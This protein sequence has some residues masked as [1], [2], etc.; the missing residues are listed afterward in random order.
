M[1]RTISGPFQLLLLTI[2]Y[3]ARLCWVSETH[4]LKKDVEKTS[5]FFE[6]QETMEGTGFSETSQKDLTQCRVCLIYLN[7]FHLHHLAG[8]KSLIFMG[9]LKGTQTS[10][11]MEWQLWGTSSFCILIHFPLEGREEKHFLLERWR[12]SGNANTGYAKSNRLQT[13]KQNEWI[14]WFHLWVG[15]ISKGKLCSE[16]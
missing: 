6:N 8:R 1:L 5:K 12:S 16:S 15:A 14:H 3:T 10:D 2:Y 9:L 7:R 4:G 11:L 13:A